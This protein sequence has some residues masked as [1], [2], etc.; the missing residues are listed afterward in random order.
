MGDGRQK[1]QNPSVTGKFPMNPGRPGSQNGKERCFITGKQ[2]A[3]LGETEPRGDFIFSAI[4]SEISKRVG[5]CSMENFSFDN[6]MIELLFIL[7]YFS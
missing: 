5:M 1:A 7:C 3:S 4:R 6:P 2:L